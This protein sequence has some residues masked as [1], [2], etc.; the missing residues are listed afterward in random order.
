MDS[1][2]R[3]SGTS[4]TTEI[5]CFNRFPCVVLPLQ[6][7]R[8]LLTCSGETVHGNFL[9]QIPIR[10]RNL[11]AFAARFLRVWSESMDV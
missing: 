8:I 10:L 2:R 7:S 3:Q 4:K 6:C 5:V 1:Y 11:V 9:G